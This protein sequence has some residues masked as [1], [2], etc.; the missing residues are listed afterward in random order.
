VAQALALLSATNRWLPS[1]Y[2]LDGINDYDHLFGVRA[3]ANLASG[4]LFPLS[5]YF[6]Q[7]LVQMEEAVSVAKAKETFD[8]FQHYN[9]QRCC[10]SNL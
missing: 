7:L 1:L 3:V 6:T 2:E 8:T 10:R 9:H 5:S 4:T